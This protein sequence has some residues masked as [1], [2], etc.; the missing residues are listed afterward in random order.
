MRWPAVSQER[1]EGLEEC[2][3]LEDDSYEEEVAGTGGGVPPRLGTLCR[4][5]APGS[6]NKDAAAGMGP[7]AGTAASLS[8]CA[9]LQTAGSRAGRVS[10]TSSCFH[11][12]PQRLPC[13]VPAHQAQGSLAKMTGW[14]SDF[15]WGRG[16]GRGCTGL[17]L[18]RKHFTVQVTCC[19][20]TLVFPRPQPRGPSFFISIL[21][22][23][24]F[25][26]CDE[27]ALARDLALAP[28][29]DSKSLSEMPLGH[30]R[31]PSRPH[32]S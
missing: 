11:I 31:S 3:D 7:V 20:P 6:R 5:V 12:M 1:G 19:Q 27:K 13:S 4:T 9:V 28:E 23:D 21:L 24:I 26:S 10:R 14:L 25:S 29:S 2:G 8:P 18:P 15:W 22:R 32:H 16:A 17:P 30:L